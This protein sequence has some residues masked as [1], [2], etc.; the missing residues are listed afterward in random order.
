M[1]PH[2]LSKWALRVAVLFGVIGFGSMYAIRHDWSKGW[3]PSLTP[4]YREAVEPVVGRD[5]ANFPPCQPIGRTAK[6]ELVY[7]MDCEQ[8]LEK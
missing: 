1:H 2:D 5:A 3:M 6:G 7:S 4:D 8:A